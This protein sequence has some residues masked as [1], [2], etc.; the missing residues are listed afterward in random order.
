MKI[1]RHGY[2]RNDAFICDN[3]G[4]VFTIDKP[5][6]EDDLTLTEVTKILF[7]ECP[8]CGFRC[9]EKTLIKLKE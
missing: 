5:E 2:F 6:N 8:D 4:C 3:C 9:H 1:I 7:P